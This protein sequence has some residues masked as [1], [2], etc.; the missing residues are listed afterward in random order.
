MDVQHNFLNYKNLSILSF[1]FG[2]PWLI[3]KI[4]QQ[5]SKRKQHQS[6]KGR[7]VLIT[8]ASSGLGESLARVFYKYGCKVILCARR[9]EELNRVKEELI[10]SDIANE[11]EPIVIKL[12]LSDISSLPSK[13]AEILKITKSIDI[14]INNGGITSRSSILD[15]NIDVDKKIME[16]NYFGTVA[17]TKAILPSMIKQKSGNIAFMS[18]VQGFI[19]IPERSSYSASKHA[20]QAF[21]DCL[22]AEIEKYKI[23]VTV[24]SPGYVKTKLSVN[25]LTGSGE[26][27]GKMDLNT[28]SGYSPDDVAK[29]TLDAIVLKQKEIVIAGFTPKLAIFLR[30]FA[31]FLY[32]YIMKLRANK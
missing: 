7:V 29:K 23:N 25:A 15:T 20:M 13:V 3:F 19:A 2:F 9:T 24:I 11:Y 32:H 12:D 28:M 18:S 17:L 1:L 30:H 8:G 22:R 4:Y 27:Y 31:P 5:K 14:L 16:V 26:M 21:A 6:L 10:K